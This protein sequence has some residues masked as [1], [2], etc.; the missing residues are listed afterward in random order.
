[1]KSGK[2]YEEYRFVRILFFVLISGMVVQIQ[3]IYVFWRFFYLFSFIITTLEKYSFILKL[4]KE[5]KD[6]FEFFI[7]HVCCYL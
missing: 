3:D 5:G 4:S 7:S 1:M 2:S 6:K